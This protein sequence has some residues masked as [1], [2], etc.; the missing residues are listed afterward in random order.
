MDGTLLFLDT[1]RN[2]S[3]SRIQSTLGLDIPALFLAGTK[4]CR[5]HKMLERFALSRQHSQLPNMVNYRL[6]EC[7]AVF[8]LTT[9]LMN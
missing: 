1:L 7:G 9:L 4:E 6:T 3:G 2:I 8:M 5:P